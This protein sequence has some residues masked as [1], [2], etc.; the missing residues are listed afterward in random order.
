MHTWIKGWKE[1]KNQIHLDDSHVFN[2]EEEIGLLKRLCTTKC[3]PPHT[4]R[5]RNL[6]D[7]NKALMHSLKDQLNSFQSYLLIII[8]IRLI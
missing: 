4:L 8:F 1:M 5:N 2:Y 7:V 6:V 3:G